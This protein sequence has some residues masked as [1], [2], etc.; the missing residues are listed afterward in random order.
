VANALLA[1]GVD[2]LMQEPS[3]PGSYDSLNKT[4]NILAKHYFYTSDKW[5]SFVVEQDSSAKKEEIRKKQP[6]LMSYDDNL[7]TPEYFV[8]AGSVPSLVIDGTLKYIQDQQVK[9][10]FRQVTLSASGLIKGEVDFSENGETSST[11]YNFTGFNLSTKI[12]GVLIKTPSEPDKH[13]N[14][15]LVD[16]KNRGAGVLDFLMHGL[17][18]GP[19]I[20]A[21][22][23]TTDTRG[24]HAVVA[25]KLDF[26]D[27]NGN[28]IIDKPE[29]EGEGE[30]KIFFI[31]PLNP[32]NAYKPGDDKKFSSIQG[33]EGFYLTS[34]D[35][36]QDSD[37]FLKLSYTQQSLAEVQ[38]AKGFDL[39]GGDTSNGRTGNRVQAADITLAMALNTSGLDPDFDIKSGA[40]SKATP[41]LVDYSFLLNLPETKAKS[42]KGYYYSNEKSDLSHDFRY[43]EVLDPAGAIA[44]PG[45]DPITGQPIRL[46]PGDD[47]YA[48]TAWSLAQ[49]HSGGSGALA[50]GERT[51][52]DHGQK[53]PFTVRLD[54]LTTGYLAPITRTS[55]GYIFTPYSIA[56][57]DKLQHFQYKGPLSWSMEDQLMLGDQDF[58][59]LHVSILVESIV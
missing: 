21:M 57:A 34:G 16:P 46:R 1:L 36:W 15:V 8:A 50:M 47:L 9:H 38:N 28:G 39:V 3:D 20:F 22:Y 25:T 58:N 7:Q 10:P 27:R 29:K 41:G 43:Y 18:R 32:S 56:N 11:K 5:S 54:E 14:E 30:G 42:L 51:S 49:R 45:L 40:L 55:E 12:D 23:Y 53:T 59:D 19:V 52:F 24:G 44:A 48:E 6:D 35:I 37:G 2:E 17:V 31:D 33:T 26:D 13:F 4:R